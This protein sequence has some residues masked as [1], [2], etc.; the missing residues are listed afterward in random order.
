MPTTPTEREV[1]EAYD[2]LAPQYAELF[3]DVRR[4]HPAD[5]AAYGEL[6][7]LVLDDGG[8]RVGDLGCGPGHWAAHLAD[9]GLEVSAV[10]LSP[11]FVTMARLAHPG[12]DVQVGS[13]SDLPLDDETLDGAVCWFSL[14]HTPPEDLAAVLDEVARV[15][16]P[17]GRLLVGFKAVEGDETEEVVAYDHRVVT[18]YLWPTDVLVAQLHDAG[19]EETHR[20]VREPGPDERFLHGALLLRK[21]DLAD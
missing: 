16:V 17:G 2:R 18:G 4:A 9:Q 14:I 12:L 11:V 20:R 8:V 6:A 3:A 19:L 21:P 5:R 1:G 10:D 13:L 7:R 15:L